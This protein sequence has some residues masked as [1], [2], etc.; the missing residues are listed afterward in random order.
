MES[1]APLRGA[2]PASL[3][4]SLSLAAALC[5]GC[6]ALPLAAEEIPPPPPAPFFLDEPAEQPDWQSLLPAGQPESLAA[7]LARVLPRDPQVR[8]ARSLFEA[9]AERRVQARSRL[10]PTAGVAMTRGRSSEFELGAPLERT[11]AR[12]EATLRW[13]LF[14]SGNDFAE[15]RA[16]LI[17]EAAAAEELR[18]A[19]EEASE[20]IAEA[21]LDVLRIESLLPHAAERLGAV[22]RLAQVVRR[23]G[24]LGK[25]S[26]ADVLQAEASLLD[27]ETAYQG[28]VADHASARRKL[29]VL[30]GASSVREINPAVPPQLG[31]ISQESLRAEAFAESAQ[32]QVQAARERSR[33]ARERVR[34]LASLLTPRIDLELRKKLDDKTTP[35]LTSAQEHGWLVSARWEIPLGG[36]LQSRRAETERRAEAAAADAERIGA[37]AA[38]ELATLGPRIAE[39]GATLARLDRQSEKYVVLVRAG[40][41][42]FAAGRRSLTQLIQLRDSRFNVEQRRAEQA[43]RLQRDRL[44]LLVLSG[45]LLPTLGL[46]EA[47]PEQ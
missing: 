14:N 3:P 21:Y 27:A 46:A 43:T 36:E 47:A 30:I 31:T 45:E 2:R 17:D 38:A 22:V 26:D 23:Q 6:L 44:R 25:L 42:Q 20:R 11:T 15:Y 34:P 41:L 4:A 8:V 40:E 7:L 32:G 33:A 19:R 12:S 29:A 5:C 18:R 10:G 37:T 1:L 35:Q 16:T 13:N 39:G 28:F 24:E 9:A